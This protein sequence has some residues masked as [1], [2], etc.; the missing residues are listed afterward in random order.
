MTA[1]E[2]VNHI[3]KRYVAAVRAK[4]VDEFMSLYGENVRIF[5]LWESWEY[6][7]AA[8]WRACVN[9]WFSSLGEEQ[10]AV[11][12]EDIEIRSAG[13]LV[14]ASFIADYAGVSPDGNVLRSLKSRGTWALSRDGSPLRIVHEH[15]SVPIR[16]SNLEAILQRPPSA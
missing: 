6:A 7:G 4:D 15:S 9:E 10:V 13:E 3:L 16:S 2:E 5:D 14:V 12:F 1:D 11:S 8:A